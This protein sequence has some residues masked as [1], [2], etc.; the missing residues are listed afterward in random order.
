VSATVPGPGT[1][2]LA[3][4]APPPVGR[5]CGCTPRTG[6]CLTCTGDYPLAPFADADHSPE[7]PTALGQ[8]ARRSDEHD[9]YR[10]RENGRYP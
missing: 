9:R 8:E 10:L 1:I 4:A 3:D 7:H 2:N 5:P 6:A